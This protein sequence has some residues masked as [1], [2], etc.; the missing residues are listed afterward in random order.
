MATKQVVLLVGPPG[1]GKSVYANQLRSTNA[2]GPYQ[3]QVVPA[4]QPRLEFEF[5]FGTDSH[6]VFS[7]GDN[8]VDAF[9]GRISD[10]SFWRV[11]P[12]YVFRLGDGTQP[13]VTVYQTYDDYCARPTV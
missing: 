9:L 10:P 5:E 3:Q 2:F 4:A 7:G 6:V 11:G 8:Q 12:I 13:I 1:S